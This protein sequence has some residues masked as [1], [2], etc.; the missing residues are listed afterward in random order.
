MPN[1]QWMNSSGVLLREIKNNL[2][3]TFG[4]KSWIRVRNQRMVGSSFKI[5][6]NR[7]FFVGYIADVGSQ[8]K[9]YI[10]IGYC[11]TLI[12]PALNG[13]GTCYSHGHPEVNI[14]FQGDNPPLITEGESH[15][16][17]SITQFKLPIFSCHL[18]DLGIRYIKVN[19]ALGV[20]L[21]GDVQFALGLHTIA[22]ER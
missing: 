9:I 5:E 6:L 13:L 17:F 3:T 2:D 16:I 19:I 4:S 14:V 18:G 20:I 7:Q 15:V 12:N 1:C 10:P 11:T 8:L 22:Y 21:K